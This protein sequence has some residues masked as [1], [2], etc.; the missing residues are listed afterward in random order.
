MKKLYA[1]DIRGKWKEWTFEVWVDPKYVDE[2]RSDGL[3]I[4]EI[5]NTIPEWWMNLGFSARL[6]CF[7]QDLFNLKNPF[8]D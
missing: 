8:A 2:W 6:W 1:L 5:V 3:H 7:F 4:D